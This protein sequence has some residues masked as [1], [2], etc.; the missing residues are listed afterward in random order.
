MF[1]I[2]VHILYAHKNICN[3]G[4]DEEEGAQDILVTCI[5]I[6]NIYIFIYIGGSGGRQV[7]SPSR[8]YYIARATNIFFGKQQFMWSVEAQEMVINPRRHLIQFTQPFPT[9]AL[10][11]LLFPPLYA[12][13]LIVS[14][15]LIM[16]KICNSS[17]DA[18]EWFGENYS[19]ALSAMGITGLEYEQLITKLNEISRNHK[20]TLISRT[21]IVLWVLLVNPGI[22]LTILGKVNN[23]RM[24]SVVLR[25]AGTQR[26]SSGGGFIFDGI[27]VDSSKCP[28]I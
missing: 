12:A 8:L 10:L 11:I 26:C 6:N 24:Q 3:I 7:F 28:G 27:I 5:Y 21:R 25:T 19:T 15:V 18:S 17:E 20:L 4:E 22:I 2:M 23:D 13:S 1:L 14:F 9:S 16:K